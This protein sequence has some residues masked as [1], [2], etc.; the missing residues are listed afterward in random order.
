[1]NAKLIGRD[2][3]EFIRTF[4]DIHRILLELSRARW[5][6]PFSVVLEQAARKHII[7]TDLASQLADFSSLRQRTLN[8]WQGE[9]SAIPSSAAVAALDQILESLRRARRRATAGK[10]ETDGPQAQGKAHIESAKKAAD[11][12]VQVLA[13]RDNE[14]ISIEEL[15]AEAMEAGW[16]PKDKAPRQTLSR[17]LQNEIRRGSRSR[18]AKGRQSES[19]RLTTAGVLYAN[20]QICLAL[21]AT[22]PDMHRSMALL[23]KAHDYSVADEDGFSEAVER[24]IGRRLPMSAMTK[25]IYLEARKCMRRGWFARNPPEAV[26]IDEASQFHMDEGVEVGIQARQLYPQGVAVEWTGLPGTV[27]ATRRLLDDPNVRVIFEATF[28]IDGYITRADLLRRHDRGW[29]IGEVKSGLGKPEVE[30]ELIDDLCYTVMVA[31]RYGVN[32]TGASLLQIDPAY[33]LGMPVEAMFVSVKE[34]PVPFAAPSPLPGHGASYDN[35]DGQAWRRV[36][37]VPRISR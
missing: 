7:V 35:R 5:D 28:A 2:T 32:V 21:S 16:S 4:Q 33:R 20:E 25:H 8:V 14:E 24:P 1:M 19:W 26:A 10:P 29:K 17:V 37:V 36:G 11:A 30:E 13:S 18:F 31:S 15:T 6:E 34:S 22:E 12:A 27:A 9:P 23:M 3:Q